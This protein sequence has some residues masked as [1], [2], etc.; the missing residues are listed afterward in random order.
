MAYFKLENPLKP[1]PNTKLSL[2][3]APTKHHD[4]PLPTQQAVQAP[5]DRWYSTSQYQFDT[6]R[7][8]L[9]HHP[10]HQTY[11]MV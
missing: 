7:L 11:F 9:A 6:D 3:Q 5:T 4:P 2:N 8:H 1:N 10:H